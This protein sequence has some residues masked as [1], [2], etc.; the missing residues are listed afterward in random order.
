MPVAQ[1][2]RILDVDPELGDGLDPDKRELARRYLV[3]EVGSIGPRRPFSDLWAGRDIERTLGLLVVS[4]LL[5]RRVR[6]VRQ[7]GVELLGP[8]DVVRPWQIRDDHA[9][10]PAAAEWRVCET[11]RLAVIDE[12]VQTSLMRFPSVMRQLFARMVQRSNT[13]ALY[14]ALAQLPRVEDRLVVLFWHLADRFGRVEPCGVVV[15][16]RLSHTTLA[17]L[18]YARRPS[19]STAL[20]NLAHR[21]VVERDRGR[22]W[23]LRGE[24]PVDLRAERV[25]RSTGPERRPA[26]AAVP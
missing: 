10:V 8:G 1:L 5:I 25:L 21:G 17:E 20:R 26:L 3:A 18:V 14:L 11:A 12:E 13:L 15:P 2:V 6:V 23:V 9:S 7:A 4:G 24:P 22:G 19:V 16:V